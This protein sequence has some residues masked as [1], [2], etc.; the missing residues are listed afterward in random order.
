VLVLALVLDLDLVRRV[1]ASGFRG[2][3]D[4]WEE[5]V[6]NELFQGFDAFLCPFR[7]FLDAFQEILNS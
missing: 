6:A 4:A 7:T 2:G 3:C 1:R 5:L